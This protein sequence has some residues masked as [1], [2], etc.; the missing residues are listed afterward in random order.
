ML[1]QQKPD[2][3]GE[4]ILN[5]QA[6]TLS[7]GADTVETGVWRIEHRE[8]AFHHKAAFVFAGG[9]REYEYELLT[10]GREIVSAH[11]GGQTASTLQWQDSALVVTFRTRH[12]GGE[13][14]I[15]FRYELTDAGRSLR[16]SEQVRGT[17]HDQENTWI[18]ERP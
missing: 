16:A 12:A 2:F 7:A 1:P 18:F 3:S 8:P 15:S 17:D 9:S 13:M 11:E 6:S 14:T 10:D 5:R 4:W